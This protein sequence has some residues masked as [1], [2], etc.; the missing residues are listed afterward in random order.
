VLL[1]VL[2]AI[3]DCLQGQMAIPKVVTNAYVNPAWHRYNQG[4]ARLSLRDDGRR[5]PIIAE[6]CGHFI[7][8]DDPDFVAR[9][10]GALL[11]RLDSSL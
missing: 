8:K 9:E 5:E 3:T 6:G 11:D 2:M 4:L 1:S 7:Q 10:I